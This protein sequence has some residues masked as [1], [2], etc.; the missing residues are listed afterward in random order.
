MATIW[1]GGEEIEDVSVIVQEDWLILVRYAESGTTPEH[2]RLYTFRLESNL[3]KLSS[4][5]EGRMVLN[6][7]PYSYARL[8]TEDVIDSYRECT[9]ARGTHWTLEQS[10]V[11][12][13]EG[14][15]RMMIE[16]KL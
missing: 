6:V 10:L 13:V 12:P 14:V 15:G 2:D 16:V 11:R 9:C 1:V 5:V 4:V 3:W 7:A 8:M